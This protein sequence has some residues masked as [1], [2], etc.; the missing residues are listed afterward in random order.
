MI[1][2]VLLAVVLVSFGGQAL[3]QRVRFELPEQPYDYELPYPGLLPQ[4]RGRRMT[5]VENLQ[6]EQ[7]LAAMRALRRDRL[8]TLGRVLFYDRE[9]SRHRN[10]SC[11]S[12]HEQAKGFADGR[13]RSKGNRGHRTGRNAMSIVNLAYYD[14]P[15]FWDGRERS[16]EQM[17]LRP[18]G[19]PVEMG[20]ARGQLV[21]RVRRLADYR[22]LFEDAFGTPGVSR[23]RIG[24]A[25]A[26][27]VRALASFGSRYD[28]GLSQVGDT[29]LPF[30][31]FTDQ[32][33]RGK[34]VFRGS[35]MGCHVARGPRH[36]GTWYTRLLQSGAVQNTGL[37]QASFRSPS[38]RNVAVGAPYMHDGRFRT[39]EQV[40]DFYAHGVRPTRNLSSRLKE[41]G[42]WGK[43]RRMEFGVPSAIVGRSVGL[44]LGPRQRRDLVAFLQTLT[45]PSFLSDPRFSDPFVR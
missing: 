6:V 10:R 8:A 2:R 17:V 29:E 31:G 34:L 13:A 36:V 39:L 14:G 23:Q 1:A 22:P 20:L 18:I 15:L 3:A 21:E 4:H 28:E 37:D 41:G 44:Q 35:C 45:D 16:L 26:A 33:N 5:S 19:D 42:Y 12:C 38:L 40:V 25:L 27:F 11:A 30:P 32:E 43:E 7:Q 9:L 24:A